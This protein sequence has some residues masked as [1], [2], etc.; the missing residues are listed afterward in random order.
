MYV[1]L[2]WFNLL[3]RIF[4]GK[5]M[6]FCV[7]MS[8][9]ITSILEILKNVFFRVVIEDISKAEIAIVRSD[10]RGP[11]FSRSNLE[12]N[13][14]FQKF[15]LD[16]SLVVEMIRWYLVLSILTNDRIFLTV[17]IFY[18][19]FSCKSVMYVLELISRILNWR[20]IFM[21]SNSDGQNNWKI[22]K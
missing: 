1:A 19:N 7:C 10:K 15:Q 4:K 17:W 22:L 16:L 14:P 12:K 11:V 3:M 20:L 2:E 5:S 9:S 21:W 18:A 8:S 13:C 6:C